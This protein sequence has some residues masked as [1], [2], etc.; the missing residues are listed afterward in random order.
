MKIG[1]IGQGFIGKNLADNFEQRWH[2]NVIVRYDLVKYPHN[3]ELIKTCDIVFIAV[4]T[5]STPEGFDDS[6]L[7][8]VAKLP[9][10]GATVV[11]KSTVFP[12]T[13]LWLD[14]EFPD[15]V[16]IHCPEFLSEDTAK[17]DTDF[18][19]RN[20]VGIE[21][22]GDNVLR[23]KA[24]EVLELLPKAPFEII[25]TFEESTLAKY[26][27]NCFFFTKNVF[28]NMMYDLSKEYN[29]KWDRLHRIILGDSRINSV[30]TNPVHKNGRGA[31]G[32]CLIKDFAAM[33]EMYENKFPG[34][35][36]GDDALFNIECKN[37]E[38]LEA[39]KK[40]IELLRGVHGTTLV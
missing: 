39:S 26:I 1:F 40:D 27:G 21:N 19:E 5:P 4:P 16:F 38:Y 12:D 33:K 2:K 7:K 17:H 9:R 15:K 20:I 23:K 32:H 3:K 34:D 11:V 18:P 6:I 28:F 8:D 31:G 36:V 37:I 29:C 35:R 13:M 22:M 25:C 10:D 30:H 24:K 14:K